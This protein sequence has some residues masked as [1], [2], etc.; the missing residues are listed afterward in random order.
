MIIAVTGHRPHKLNG[1]WDG[2][3]P[4]SDH[5]RAQFE[6][7]LTTINPTKGISGGAL[8]VDLLWAEALIKH[9][10]PFILAIP[11]HNQ[12]K[13]WAPKQRDRYNMIR[14]HTLCIQYY[15]SDKPYFHGCMQK[16]NIW[17]VDNC[18]LLVAVHDG[19]EGGTKNC[20][21]YAEQV[22]KAILRINPDPNSLQFMRQGMENSS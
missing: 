5:I 20:I 18:N 6:H 19:S 1:E 11:C 22:N 10:V 17:M 14:N 9:N 4:V 3:G 2:I 7:I 15:V 12:E 16:R 13:P 21:E 8:G